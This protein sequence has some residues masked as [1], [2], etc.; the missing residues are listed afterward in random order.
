[1]RNENLSVRQIH[2]ST[3]FF[4]EQHWCWANFC[5]FMHVNVT[6]FKYI[7]VLEALLAGH[8]PPNDLTF[9]WSWHFLIVALINI[10]VPGLLWLTEASK[11]LGQSI[12][13][14]KDYSSHIMNCK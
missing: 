5:F 4:M 14:K 3:F 11:T 7:Q 8:H 9:S 2:L 6:F 13:T 12:K 10:S 1:M